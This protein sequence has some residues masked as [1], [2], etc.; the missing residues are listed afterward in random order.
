ME[1][2]GEPCPSCHQLT[3]ASHGS[4]VSGDVPDDEWRWDLDTGPHTCP[5]CGAVFETFVREVRV[6]GDEEVAFIGTRLISEPK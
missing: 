1:H 6:A 4:P 3:D 5:H 2:Y